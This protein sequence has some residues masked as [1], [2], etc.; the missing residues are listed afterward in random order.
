MTGLEILILAAIFIGAAA[1]ALL[2]ET[3]HT[4][5]APQGVI[6]LFEGTAQK[7]LVIAGEVN[8]YWIQ[9]GTAGGIPVSFPR[10]PRP[11]IDGISVPVQLLV[12]SDPLDMGTVSV[13]IESAGASGV[14]L[15]DDRRPVGRSSWTIAWKSGVLPLHHADADDLL[16]PG[17]MFG[18]LVVTP[19]PLG[20][21]EQVTITLSPA[22]GIPLVVKRGI[23]PRVSPV[24]LLSL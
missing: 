11:G 16:E 13:A 23:P 5:R 20:P 2:W 17:E 3:H 19:G 10:D 4:G 15:R 24:T 1:S 18:L 14:L 7:T 21:G 6:P 22:G 8:G 12:G 9:D